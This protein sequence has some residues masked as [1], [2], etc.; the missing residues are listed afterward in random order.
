MLHWLFTI[1]HLA[2]LLLHLQLIFVLY[3]LL[4]LH[5]CSGGT[6]S[7]VLTGKSSRES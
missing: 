4:A 6:F 2:L 1:V 5:Q 7:E 3:Q